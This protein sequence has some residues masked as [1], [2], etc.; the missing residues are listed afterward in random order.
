MG[1][2]GQQSRNLKQ[3]GFDEG[4]AWAGSYSCIRIVTGWLLHTIPKP[5][6]VK[7]AAKA[8]NAP[9]AKAAPAAVVAA[10]EPAVLPAGA[11]GA[12]YVSEGV[13]EGLIVKVNAAMPPLATLFQH[14][15]CTKTIPE[16]FANVLR[17]ASS[18]T[19]RTTTDTIKSSQACIQR[20]HATNIGALII[21]TGVWGYIIQL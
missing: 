5:P 11:A 7:G 3:F 9:K 4:R 6:K 19:L 2:S 1:T 14:S 21:I 12:R 17:T 16:C 18:K 8:L 10:A 13:N 15:R 20:R